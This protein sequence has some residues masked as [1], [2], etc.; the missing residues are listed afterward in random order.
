MAEAIQKHC[1]HPPVIAVGQT[2]LKALLVLIRDAAWVVAPDSGPVHMAVAF[3][4]PVIGLYATSNPQRTG[5]WGQNTYV[6]NA[7]P[8][9]VQQYLKTQPEALKWGQRVRHP[10]A[11]SVIQV[12]D[13]REKMAAIAQDTGLKT[14]DE[15]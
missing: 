15:N 13:I 4:T 6:V 11:M 3:K 7:Y 9:A 5:P 1:Q 10:E 2:S 12:E 8:R 14:T